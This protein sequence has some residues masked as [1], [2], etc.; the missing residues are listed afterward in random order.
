MPDDCDETLARALARELH[1]ELEKRL[2]ALDLVLTDNRRRMVS[3]RT[4][5]GRLEVRV[6]HM[7]VGCSFDVIDALAALRSNSDR[8]VGRARAVV[9]TYIRENRDSINTEVDTSQLVTQG[10]AHDLDATLERALEILLELEGETAEASK[11]D[12]VAITWG[13]QGR[14]R[15]SIR[16]GSYDFD[17]RL[18]RVHPSLDESWVPGYFV[19]FVVY[20]ELLHAVIPPNSSPEG[21]RI[22]HPPEFREREAMFPRYTEA[23]QWESENLGRL[24]KR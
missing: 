10:D 11:L 3:L 7:F 5:K 2:G 15:R 13:R 22:V 17:R 12:D 18:I 24:L 21:R 4:R 16:F 8:E 6:H 14:G 9:R 20:H 23:T 19:E 1:I